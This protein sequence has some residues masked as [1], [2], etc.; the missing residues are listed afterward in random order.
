[1]PGPATCSSSCAAPRRRSYEQMGALRLH[2]AD[3][4]GLL[5][6]TSDWIFAWITEFP[7]PGVE[8]R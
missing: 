6:G 8:R 1:M 2:M 4:L 5:E 7:T 3:E